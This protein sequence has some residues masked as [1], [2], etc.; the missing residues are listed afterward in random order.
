M[1]L[2]R[3]TR[4][5]RAILGACV[6]ALVAASC[7]RDAPTAPSSTRPA[8]TAQASDLLGTTVGLVG[9]LL[10]CRPL[11]YAAD[12]AVI[13]SGGG[14]LHLGVHTLVIP[15]GALDHPVFIRGEAPSD[16]VNSVRLYPE[17]LR[18][19]RPAALTMSYAN[20]GLV[21]WLL[22]RIAYTTDG[23]QILYFIPTLG[24]LF[25]KHVT[26]QVEHFSRYAVAW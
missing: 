22:P 6:A 14:V 15:P 16:S 25:T 3:S 21:T 11:P 7:G 5:T 10:T 26:G 13:G 12:S 23:L 17:G 2:R 20:C 18:F 1:D 24:N 9:K 8:A 19:E 4:L